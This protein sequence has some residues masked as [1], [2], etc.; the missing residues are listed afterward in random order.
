MADLEVTLVDVV[1]RPIAVVRHQATWATLP[2]MIEAHHR[3]G[4]AMPRGG[5]NVMVYR[6]GAGDG[7]AIELEIGVEVVGA[8]EPTGEV[9]LAEMPAGRAVTATH[10][11]PYPALGETHRAVIAW[12]TDRGHA[13]DGISWEVYGDWTDDDAQLCTEVFHRVAT[14]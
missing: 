11:G 9:A 12:A 3:A 4:H 14:R 1:A 6:A 8:F 5:A 10:V 7:D 2:R 13:L